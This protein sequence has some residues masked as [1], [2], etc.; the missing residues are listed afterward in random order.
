MPTPLTIV[1][2]HAT[3][4]SWMQTKSRLRRFGKTIGQLALP[5][6]GHHIHFLSYL[7][8]W[9]HTAK[10]CPDHSDI[11]SLHT[12]LA[13]AVF[14]AG[15]SPASTMQRG[16]LLQ[17]HLVLKRLGIM[18]DKYRTC[19]H[20]IPNTDLLVS[21]YGGTNALRMEWGAVCIEQ[22]AEN[23][24]DDGIYRL[25]SNLS[26][27]MVAR[28]WLLDMKTE[29]LYIPSCLWSSYLYAAGESWFTFM[30]YIA[31]N[32]G[33]VAKDVKALELVSKWILLFWRNYRNG[34]RR[35][36][37]GL[38]ALIK[39]MIA[40]GAVEQ[41]TRTRDHPILYCFRPEFIEYVLRRGAHPMDDTAR[42][43]YSQLR[44][45]RTHF[46]LAHLFAYLHRFLWDDRR[47]GELICMNWLDIDD[48]LYPFVMLVGLDAILTDG[49]SKVVYMA[50]SRSEDGDNGRISSVKLTA[51]AFLRAAVDGRR[52]QVCAPRVEGRPSHL[53]S[54]LCF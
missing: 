23:N 13:K 26:H 31:R 39:D 14:L 32:P 44:S 3:G 52:L 5:I 41:P 42:N 54:L 22:Q 48:L 18:R 50:L 21:P 10:P 34:V 30:E 37:A 33:S 19:M 24:S 51:L 43:I 28:V 7:A 49:T 12:H 25:A 27:E 47:A 46:T 17:Q 53:M 4:V 36:N 1:T 11:S 15:Y 29:L 35:T 2:H 8:C 9:Y 16:C 45:L 6:N 40:N 20:S 38:N